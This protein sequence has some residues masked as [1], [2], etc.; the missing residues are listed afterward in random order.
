MPLEVHTTHHP[1]YVLVRPQG[2]A[3][4][5]EF[6][7]M[8]QA[9]GADSVSWTEDAVIVDLRGITTDYSFT[10]QLRIGEGVGRNLSHLRKAAAVVQQHRITRVGEKAANHTGAHSCVFADEQEAIAWV[11]C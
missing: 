5:E 2:E 9:I 3:T 1:G 8:L 10:E 7:A 11:L 4:L 6:L